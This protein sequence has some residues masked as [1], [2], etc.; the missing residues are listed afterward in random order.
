MRKIPQLPQI[1]VPI[2]ARNTGTLLD[3][4][5]FAA[6][7]SAD[8]LEWRAD[9]FCG[10]LDEHKRAADLFLRVANGCPAIFTYRSEAEAKHPC[11]LDTSLQQ[12]LYTHIITQT[13][14][15]YVDCEIS[16]PAPFWRSVQENTKQ[17]EKILIGSYHDF[18]NTPD[19]AF[20]DA[21]IQTTK[22]AGANIAK[23]AVMAQK[24]LDVFRLLG[25]AAA[26]HS[27]LALPVIAVSM[28][29]VG[30]ISRIIGFLFGAPLTFAA[31]IQATAPGQLP[32]NELRQQ[33]TELHANICK[34]ITH[35]AQKAK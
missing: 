29:D 4:L 21:Q 14:F 18:D 34:T 2:V 27:C 28:G 26:A 25:R 15:A 12:E 3:E 9:Y 19:D 33:I 17:Q 16:R 35:A 7:A 20:L 13:N 30:R 24:E 10:S 22:A 11:W 32:A 6:A 5:R 31:G 1:C 23:L 8:M